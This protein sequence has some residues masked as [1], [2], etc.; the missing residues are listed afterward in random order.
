MPSLLFLHMWTTFP[1]ALSPRP[2][3]LST[4]PDCPLFLPSSIYEILVLQV[5]ALTPAREGS[6]WPSQLL[7][8]AC[9]CPHTTPTKFMC[10]KCSRVEDLTFLFQCNGIR[11][12]SLWVVIRLWRWRLHEGINH[13]KKIQEREFSPPPLSLCLCLTAH[14]I[15]SLVKI[16]QEGSQLQTSKRA[17]TRTPLCWYHDLELSASRAVNNKVHGW[18]PD[19]MVFCSSSQSWLRQLY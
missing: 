12:W 19:L 14:P 1:S 8:T 16:Q 18:S 9:L 3:S 2:P 17:P 7:W 6:S 5:S 10:W 13:H 11:R 15:P 4:S